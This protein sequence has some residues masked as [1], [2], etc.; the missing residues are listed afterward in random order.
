MGTARIDKVVTD[1]EINRKIR[2]HI[3]STYRKTGGHLAIPGR[4]TKTTFR[5]G[6]WHFHGLCRCLFPFFSLITDWRLD[7]VLSVNICTMVIIQIQRCAYIQPVVQIVHRV[8][9]DTRDAISSCQHIR[10]ER[11]FRSPTLPTA[12]HNDIGTPMLLEKR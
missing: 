1:T 10:T 7:R 12:K 3:F 2:H 9:I 4:R 8:D 6:Q 5:C 11:R